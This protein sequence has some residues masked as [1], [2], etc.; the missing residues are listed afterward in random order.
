MATLDT[1]LIREEVR[2]IVRHARSERDAYDRVRAALVQHAN[3]GSGRWVHSLEVYF[4]ENDDLA[5]VSIQ[6]WDRYDSPVVI[7][8][9]VGLERS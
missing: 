3:H 1:D 7:E 6:I 5:A 8:T 9:T 4:Y 2:E